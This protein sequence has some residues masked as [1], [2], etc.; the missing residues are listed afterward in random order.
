MISTSKRAGS[1]FQQATRQCGL[2]LIELM[3]AV[4]IGL[5]VTLA[6]GA[7][8]ISTQQS[9]RENEAATRMQENARFAV[10]MLTA[11]L[12]HAG[13]LGDVSDPSEVDV[14]SS[15]S[16]V[17]TNCAGGH[18][19]LISAGRYQVLEYGQALV[20]PAAS[21]AFADCFTGTTGTALPMNGTSV[22]AVKRTGTNTVETPVNNTVYVRADMGDAQMR[23]GGNF[24]ISQGEDRE[25][26]SNVYYI[27]TNNW[28]RRFRL[29]PDG[30]NPMAWRSEAIA[31]GIEAFHIEFGLDADG[32]GNPDQ[33][34]SPGINA[35]STGD[36]TINNAVTATVHVL[37]RT[38][39][40]VDNYIE[41]RIYNL[42]DLVVDYSDG[43]APTD[44]AGRHYMRRVYTA[45]VVMRNLRNQVILRGQG[46]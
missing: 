2:T 18:F 43:S 41:D 27:D 37:A 26:R 34:Y 23:Y 17:A 29:V 35:D 14:P 20:D 33:I 45:T 12:R 46:S 10:E 42:G 36:D 3:V 21:A 24:S 1:P 7:L 15:L 16:N 22:L 32:D 28:L 9:Y 38:E 31:G 40:G 5:L 6:V 8:F 19:S 44:D 4:A 39:R 11:D 13:Y 25:Y 30:A